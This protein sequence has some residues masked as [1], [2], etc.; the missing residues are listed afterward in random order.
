[1]VLCIRGLLPALNHELIDG[2]R[3]AGRRRQT[4]AFVSHFDGL[5]VSVFALQR[6][7]KSG[8]LFYLR[9]GVLFKWFVSE[10]PYLVHETPKT[11]HV[12]GC[13]VLLIVH[14]LQHTNNSACYDCS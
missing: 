10:T 4:Q 8:W 13:R 3:A 12:T 6:N 2:S 1:M 7:R 14:S 5:D 9:V 11:P